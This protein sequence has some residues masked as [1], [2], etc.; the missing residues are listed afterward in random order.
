MCRWIQEVQLLL[1]NPRHLCMPKLRSPWHKMLQSSAFHAV[2]SSAA[3]CWMT[4][5][6]AEFCEFYLP[7]PHLTPSLRGIPSSYQVHIWSGKTRM[8]GLQSGEGRIMI[9]SSRLGTIHQ[10][11]RHTDSHVAI[12][13]A[14]LT[15]YV[16]RQKQLCMKYEINKF[17]WGR[18]C[19]GRCLQC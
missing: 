1:T 8:A 5:I 15:H 14:S 9:D 7:I 2:L 17:T 4:A 19:K 10:R 12:A 6:L 11:G 13:N 16:A 3:L 18:P